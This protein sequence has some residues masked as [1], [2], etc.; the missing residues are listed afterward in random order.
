M[1]SITLSAP[2][3]VASRDR[4]FYDAWR[5]FIQ[6]NPHLGLSDTGSAAEGFRR[7]HGQPLIDA[8]SL[9]RAVS[10]RWCATNEFDSQALYVCTAGRHG[11]KPIKRGQA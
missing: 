4:G 6:M 8:G 11:T 2:V 7:R 9:Y 10:G 5:E 1:E 3:A